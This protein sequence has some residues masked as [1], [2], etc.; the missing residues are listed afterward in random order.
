M[1]DREHVLQRLELLFVEMVRVG[2]ERR[3]VLRLLS[4]PLV[5][6]LATL[7]GE[8]SEN[9]LHVFIDIFVDDQSTRA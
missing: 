9:V 1:I 6:N 5:S 3:V 2:M 8:V 4:V 7:R